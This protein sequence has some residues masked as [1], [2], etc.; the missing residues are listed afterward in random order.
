MAQ[1]TVWEP[2]W[3]EEVICTGEGPASAMGDWLHTGELNIKYI[4]IKDKGNHVSH[5]QGI[6]LLA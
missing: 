4:Y 6:A 3:D 1:Y 2:K 5:V